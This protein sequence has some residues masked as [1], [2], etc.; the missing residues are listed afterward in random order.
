MLIGSSNNLFLNVY[1]A[2]HSESTNYLTIFHRTIWQLFNT[3]PG[4]FLENHL[5]IVLKLC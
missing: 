3:L 4:A 5:V 2:I 1:F